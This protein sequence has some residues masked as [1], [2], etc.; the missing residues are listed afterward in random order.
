MRSSFN[1]HFQRNAKI[2]TVTDHLRNIINFVLIR[3]VYGYS[4]SQSKLPHSR[5]YPSRSWFSIKRPRKDARLSWPSLHI[6]QISLA[7]SVNRHMDKLHFAKVSGLV[8]TVSYTENQKPDVSESALC[9]SKL[10][11]CRCS[12]WLDVVYVCRAADTDTELIGNWISVS[13]HSIRRHA[14][15]VTRHLPPGHLPPDTCP[16]ESHHR[17]HLPIG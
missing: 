12:C 17:R 6:F 16:L 13:R 5:R 4:S 11:V 8:I 3:K 7:Y 1:S 10:G 2:P 15:P 14:G 9:N